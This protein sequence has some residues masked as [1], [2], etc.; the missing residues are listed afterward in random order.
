MRERKTS[1]AKRRA[2]RVDE[3]SPSMF[4]GDDL[5]ATHL[6][7]VDGMLTA[8]F[9]GVVDSLSPPLNLP[10]VDVIDSE[11]GRALADGWVLHATNLSTSSSIYSS[12]K[13][14]K[15][16]FVRF[17][18]QDLDA[19]GTY[20]ALKDLDTGMLNRF[21]R[22]TASFSDNAASSFRWNIFE[23]LKLLQKSEVWKDRLNSDLA[24][25]KRSTRRITKPSKISPTIDKSMYDQLWVKAGDDC[26]RLLR[27]YAEFWAFE[28]QYRDLDLDI[29]A[30]CESPM[31]MA[32]HLSRLYPAQAVPGYNDFC[33]LKGNYPVQ[34]LFPADRYR[35]AVELILPPIE[36]FV[37]AIIILTQFFALNTSVVQGMKY[38]EDYRF[39][40]LLGR[41]RLQIFPKKPRADYERQRNV[42]TVTDA[43]D[44]PGQVIRFVE[45]AS[46][47]T[48]L[49]DPLREHLL[50]VW[51]SSDKGKA[52]S[53]GR[54]DEPFRLAFRDFQRKHRLGSVDLASGNESHIQLR[55]L[56]SSTLDHV[57][58]ITGG[59]L[60]KVKSVSNHA[61]LATI[62][63]S[64][65]SARMRREGHERLGEAN[66]EWVRQTMSGQ[67]VMATN[68]PA[69]LDR[70]SATPGYRC[71]DPLSSPVQGEK[72]GRLCG[73]Y[74]RCPICPLAEV[75]KTP[76]GFIYLTQL[77][78]RIDAARDAIGGVGW[79]GR[80]AAVRRVLAF[81][82]LRSFPDDVKAASASVSV[83]R[84]PMVE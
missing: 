73:A 19:T 79:L 64:Y 57:H 26:E 44:N 66:M 16:G 14:L 55:Q 67:K 41:E 69:T 35:E 8:V 72:K 9:P 83:P 71:R 60:L 38:E 58:Q 7:R 50:F 37:P 5:A 65:R 31:A 75:E 74:G 47:R 59:D 76:E 48:R 81:R 11:M 68:R 34:K 39:D 6:K 2:E 22:W 23:P 63:R 62:Q 40:T 25:P 30:A 45:N 3:A 61:S 18:Q 78:E 46:A 33:R 82:H 80:W 28:E 56:R 4:V 1:A 10:F 32:L 54:S 29:E 52:M 77:L 13:N 70:A 24:F 36:A 53:F 49:I 84:L 42:V 21:A 15:Y 17:L 20:P 51:Y 12:L 27:T 43:P